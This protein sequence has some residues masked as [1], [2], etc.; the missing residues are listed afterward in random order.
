M[1][2]KPLVCTVHNDNYQCLLE[3][4]MEIRERN[5]YLPSAYHVLGLVLGMCYFLELFYLILTVAL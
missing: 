3:E 2:V 1:V 4:R 5:K